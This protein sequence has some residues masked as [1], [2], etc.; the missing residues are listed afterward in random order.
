MPITKKDFEKGSPPE[1]VRSSSVRPAVEDFMKSNR[2]TA[3]STKEIA[4][5]LKANKATVNHT[6]RKLEEEAK[7]ER[8]V[9]E[10]VIFNRWIAVDEE[11]AQ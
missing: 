1:T 6:C 5:A 9:V 2:E 10:G 7:V 8:R 4:E 3:Y 11:V